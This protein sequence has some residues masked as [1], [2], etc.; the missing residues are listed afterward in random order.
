MRRRK[1]V[2]TSRSG[3]FYDDS[4]VLAVVYEEPPPARLH[5]SNRSNGRPSI[6]S[7]WSRLRSAVIKASAFPELENSQDPK[8][9]ST[10]Q[11]FLQRKFIIEPHF[12]R[13]KSLM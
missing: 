6:G 11:D 8:P 12:A 9:T 1:S 10:V 5:R 13:R 2:V 7:H 3:S 4:W